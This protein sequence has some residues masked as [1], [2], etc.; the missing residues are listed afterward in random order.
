VY[1]SRGRDVRV[2][3]TLNG[4]PARTRPRTGRDL[5]EEYA[6]L[7]DPPDAYRGRWVALI[8]S[9]VVAAAQTPEELRLAIPA[10]L[11]QP[12]LVAQIAS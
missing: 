7:R 1:I 10:D 5:Q 6:W 8:G 9:S 4:S 12:P 3:L 2:C 11:E